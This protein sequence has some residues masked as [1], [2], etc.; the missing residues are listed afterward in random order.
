MS[1][2]IREHIKEYADNHQLG[3]TKDSAELRKQL[4]TNMPCCECCSSGKYSCTA[5]APCKQCSDFLDDVE[6]HT[7][8]QVAASY[9]RGY[10]NGAEDALAQ[11][12][13]KNP[14]KWQ[15]RS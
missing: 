11:T 12:A 5:D 14:N 10:N 7:A 6:A 8:A 4:W 2:P 15:R 13:D 1:S 3:S 9:E